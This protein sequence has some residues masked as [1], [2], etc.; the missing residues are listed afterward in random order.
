MQR[1]FRRPC[2]DSSHVT[3]PSKL[4]FYYYYYYLIVLH[5]NVGKWQNCPDVETGSSK[6]ADFNVTG[7]KR[8]RE[9]TINK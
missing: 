6:A 8:D 7:I 4:S 1:L 5:S 3:A 2:S 9:T